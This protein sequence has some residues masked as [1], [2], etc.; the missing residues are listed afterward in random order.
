MSTPGPTTPEPGVPNPS[1]PTIPAPSEPTV[2]TPTEPSPF[3]ADTD[4]VDDI[5]SIRAV[6]E[7]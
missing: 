4:L 7:R 5:T 6:G 3:E 1:E 2:P